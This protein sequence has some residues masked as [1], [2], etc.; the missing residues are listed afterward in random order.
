VKIALVC[1]YDWSKPGGVKA[2]VENLA[3]AMHDRHEVRIFA[4]ASGSVPAAARAPQIVDLGRPVPVRF[5]R[6]VAPVALSPLAA[7]RTVEALRAFEP[8]VVHVHEPFV[9]AVSAA[10]ATWGPKPVIG[11]FHSWSD[12]DRAYRSIRRPARRV[13]LNLD[14]RVAVSPAAQQYAGGAL[15]VPLGM[16]RVIPNGVNAA[17]FTDAEPLK[18]LVDPARPLVLFVGRLEPRKGLEVLVRAF[19]RLRARRPDVRLCVVGEG[20]E[21]ERCQRMIPPSIRPDVLFVGSVSQ[22]E[23]PRYHASAD[24]FASPATGG[25]SFGIV[26]LEAM[27][28]GLPV[29]ASDIPG[30]R[31]VVKE[32]RQGRL[33]PPSDAFV[34]AD[35]LDA[36]LANDKLRRAM[37]AEGRQTA[38][39]YAWPVVAAEIESLY[40]EVIRRA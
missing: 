25:E 10:A 19:L 20:P 3:G 1:P 11:T 34:L 30:Y 15:A 4:P 8:H 16:F 14:A 40:H 7:R 33:V 12:H 13:A 27:A 22:D 31:T 2:H 21:R 26:L 29:V 35:A 39:R 18:H 32:G 5:N 23:L 37:A 24:V 36:L 38:Q 9:P 28:A 6:S 17:A